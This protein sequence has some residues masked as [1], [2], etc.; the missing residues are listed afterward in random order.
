MCGIAG[1]L[2]LCEDEPISE[3][4]LREMLAMIRHRGPDQ[5]GIYLDDAIG[6]GNARLSIVDLASG[7]QPIATEDKRFWIVYNGEIFN[8]REL[9]LELEAKGHRFET[10]CDT[11]VFL[12]L[13][14]EEGT[15]C[16]RRLNGQ[17]AVAIWDSLKRELFLARD[18]LGIRPLFYHLRDDALVFGS[19]IK[20]L[21]V[22]PAID[23]EIDPAALDQIFTGWSCLPPQTAVQD[24]RQLSP[25]HYALFNKKGL[26]I[27][28]YWQPFVDSCG[29]NLNVPNDRSSETDLLQ[30]FR[31]LLADSTRL[32][33]LADVPV[34]AYLSGGLDSSIIAALIRRYATG[35]I[36]T[37]SIAF[38]DF[39][40]DESEHQR[41]MAQHL[42]TDHQVVEASYADIGEIFPK[43]VWH[44]ET[45]LLRTA[46]AP[47]FLLSRLVNRSGYKVVL[48]GEG[49]DEFLAGYDI[50]KEAKIRAFWSRQPDSTMRPKLFQRIYPDL[51]KLAKLSPKYLASFFGERLTEVDAPDY[52]HAIRWRN[53]RRTQRFF[54]PELS[55]RIRHKSRSILDSVSIPDGFKRWGLL[56]RAQY[57][58]VTAFLSPYLLSSQGDRV[59]MANSVEGRFP[60]LD[61]RVAE[62]CGKLPGKFKLRALRDKYLLRELGRDLLPKDICNRPK[63]PYRAPIHRCFFNSRAPA[64][65]REV[66]SETALREAGLFHSGAV[67]KLVTKIEHGQ[68]L[69]ETD[70]MA[71]AGIIS[72]Q[73]FFFQFVKDFQRAEP[74]SDRDDVKVCDRRTHLCV[75]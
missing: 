74:L 68:P 51:Q 3:L 36:D 1:Y 8:H 33:L 75:A 21:A 28:R 5:F 6:M 19:E 72:S 40:F 65:V 62:F 66:L 48:T 57:L 17:F 69:G 58:E 27:E 61:Y 63:K 59:A 46:P 32:R 15:A 18:R 43:V 20:A 13:Y 41:R 53:T 31:E 29:G 45:P 4:L 9:R 49:A 54:S 71:I 38:T 42:G 11:E 7:Q 26:F 10:H 25:G 37:F 14:E 70:D 30:A 35:R 34:G 22:H 50:F 73:L 2:N 47:M 23:L 56:E 44:C 67:S 16:L 55:D 52:S 12:H 39:A 24:I 60:F 64:Y